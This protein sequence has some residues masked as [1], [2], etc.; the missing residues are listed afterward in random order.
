MQH[1]GF[2]ERE[3]AVCD[4][5]ARFRASALA[6]TLTFIRERVVEFAGVEEMTLTIDPGGFVLAQNLSQFIYGFPVLGG[7]FGK[8][9]AE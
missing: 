1:E 4:G 9:S 8:T 5:R 6:L 3:W 2:I 7:D